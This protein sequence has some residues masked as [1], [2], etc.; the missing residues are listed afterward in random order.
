MII[1][2]KKIKEINILN[3]KK[4]EINKE[5]LNLVTQLKKTITELSDNLK[6]YQEKN[7]KLFEQVLSFQKETNKLKGQI[8]S[9]NNYINAKVPNPKED[10]SNKNKN[11]D[12]FFNQNI[13]NI[14]NYNN[15]NNNYNTNLDREIKVKD[16]PDL[17]I[18]NRL[19]LG[20]KKPID[21]YLLLL[22]INK[23][24]L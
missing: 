19:K 15:K 23:K 20:T 1:E 14:I 4:E 9:L 18:R 10:K 22:Q 5:Y 7:Q 12:K 21:I 8:K 24:I 16:L 3:E 13:K 6:I 17:I 2:I 11:K